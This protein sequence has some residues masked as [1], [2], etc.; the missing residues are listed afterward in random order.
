MSNKRVK[1]KR[2]SNLGPRAQMKNTAAW[3]D[4]NGGKTIEMSESDAKALGH[5][6]IIVGEAKADTVTKSTFPKSN[7]SSSRGNFD[8][9][10]KS[11][12]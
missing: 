10:S 2:S 1:V 7:A 11:D 5:K 4:L 9:G 8:K 6:V 3:Y 12:R